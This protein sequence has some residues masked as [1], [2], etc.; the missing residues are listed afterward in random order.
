MTE[1]RP[2]AIKRYLAAMKAKGLPADPILTGSR[3]DKAKLDNPGFL[4]DTRQYRT[5]VNNLVRAS[6]DNG[7]GFDVGLNST[8]LDLGVVGHAAM[9]CRTVRDSYHVWQ[10]FSHR[11][12]GVMWDVDTSSENARSLTLTFDRLDPGDPLYRFYVEEMLGMMHMIGQ[13]LAGEQ[14]TVKEAAFAYPAPRYR[15]RYHELL[16]CPVHFG[17]GR[18]EIVVSA[19]WFE[20]NVRTYDAELNRL[21]WNYCDEVV[22]RLEKEQPL[23]ARI[24]GMFLKSD[25]ILPSLGQVARELNMSTRTLRRRLQEAGTT[26]RAQADGFR[27]S[28]ALEYLRRSNLSA[29]EIGFRLGFSE[30]SAFRHAFKSWTGKTVTQYRAEMS[31]QHSGDVGAP[32]TSR[33]EN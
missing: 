22:H 17:A 13:P 29:K 25:D 30:P 12:V 19:A 8:L 11:L 32:R 24:Q 6:G 28:R 15:Q 27:M 10:Q 21:C 5:V 18:S 2:V 4:I 9:T 26:Y 33:T 31:R 14:A 16:R 20:K 7:I 1:L 23:I 3:I